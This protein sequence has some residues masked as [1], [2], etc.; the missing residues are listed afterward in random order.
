RRLAMRLSNVYMWSFELVNGDLATAKATFINVWESLGYANDE[1]PVEF[2][3]SLAF[4]IIP[5]DQART[6]QAAQACI[7]GETAEFEAGYRIRHKDGSL[8]WNLSRG[9]V[10][11]D[12][13]GAPLRFVGTSVDVTR[14]KQMEEEARRATEQLQLALHLSG[15]VSW[16][17]E[18]VDG[19]LEP[20]K[21]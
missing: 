10:I 6:F 13:S 8:H 1:V 19:K 12:A 3:T 5:E 18:L 21:L 15:I 16:S 4:A 2:A 14:L 7:N 11:R 9:E 20:A 17:F